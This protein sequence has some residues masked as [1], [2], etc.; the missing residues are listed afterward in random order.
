MDIET[1]RNHCLSKKGVSEE[2]PFD[3]DTLVFKV[4]GKIFAITDLETFSS[5]NLKTDP[6]MGAELQEKYA[7]VKPG[8]HMN[9]KH[10]ITV[11][12][13]GM[14]GDKLLLEWIDNSY[15]LVASKLSKSE[16]RALES[17]Q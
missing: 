5:I 7:S 2:F 16:K 15:S 14:I 13:D 11:S 3:K 17:M 4:L 12:I 6:E 9:K 1:F 10:W 8:Y